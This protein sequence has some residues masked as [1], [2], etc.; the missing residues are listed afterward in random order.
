VDRGFGA[1][2]W[3]EGGWELWSGSSWEI[4]VL[5]WFK[6]PGWRDWVWVW[7][8]ERLGKVEGNGF[9]FLAAR[10]DV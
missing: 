8:A 1:S 7:E 3:S 4:G 2:S 10:N 9:F 5:R 6:S